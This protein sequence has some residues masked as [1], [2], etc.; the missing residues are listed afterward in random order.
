M[1]PPTGI[2]R[3]RIREGVPAGWAGAHRAA[4]DGLPIP[5]ARIVRR[6]ATRRSRLRNR[7]SLRCRHVGDAAPRNLCPGDHLAVEPLLRGRALAEHAALEGNLAEGEVR[8]DAQ[9]SNAPRLWCQ[10]GRARK[11]QAPPPELSGALLWGCALG[12]RFV[13][14]KDEAKQSGSL[15]PHEPCRW[16]T[17]HPG[18]T[19]KPLARSLIGPIDQKRS[20]T[21]QI[22]SPTFFLS[23]SPARVRRDAEHAECAARDD[24]AARH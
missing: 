17:F 13:L 4:A 20:P 24:V 10:S 2:T 1:R 5:V 6:R 18:P 9:P 22:F 16:W 11:M 3:R 14:S 23:R 8:H 21:D 19:E 7:L 12:Q 15:V